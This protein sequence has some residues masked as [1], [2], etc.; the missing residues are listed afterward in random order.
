[1]GDYRIQKEIRRAT[2]DIK[3]IADTAKKEGRSLNKY[4]IKI[5]MMS[6]YALTPRAAEN[7]LEIVFNPNDFKERDDFYVPLE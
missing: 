6:N 4:D 5:Q 3:N 7:I 1:M 2:I